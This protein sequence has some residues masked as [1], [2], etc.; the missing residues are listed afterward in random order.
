VD[1]AALRREV[2]SRRSALTDR[3]SRSLAVEGR[4]R[5]LP[6]FGRAG[7]VA[8]YVG[9]GEEV[10][11]VA[12]IEDALARHLTVAVPWRDGNDLH[13]ARILSLAELVPV[14]FG[15]LEPPSG[16]ASSPERLLPPE[17]AGL[18]LIPGV[19]FDREGGR[20]GHGKGF[21]D[22]LLERAGAGPL[23]IALAFECQMVE[24]VPMVAGDERMD[25]VVTEDAVYRVSARTASG[26]R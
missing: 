4:L 15:L 3:A 8:S 23:R 1:K 12:L 6:E 17:D 21:Y 11:T 19:A 10:A 25:L 2:L 26:G 5:S 13:L 24:R 7:T 9:V 16:L 18:L 14:S 22:R 20:L